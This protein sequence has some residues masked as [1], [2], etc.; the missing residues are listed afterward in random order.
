MLDA[1]D[2]FI[3]SNRNQAIKSCVELS[4]DYQIGYIKAHSVNSDDLRDDVL[5]IF[6]NLKWT[7][8]RLKELFLTPFVLLVISLF[9]IVI[10]LV[11]P[12]LNVLDWFDKATRIKAVRQYLKIYNFDEFSSL[13]DLWFSY[14]IDKHYPEKDRIKILQQWLEML[15]PKTV[16]DS[17]NIPNRL[18]SQIEAQIQTRKR[19]GATCVLFA[20]TLDTVVRN[21]SNEYP[22]L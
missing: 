18:S 22:L 7:N 13:K 21:I 6:A 8:M 15:Y 2:I 12:V 3:T 5:G 20:D 17:I 11:A 16:Y 14:G 19:I 4:V 10:L 1:T 9:L